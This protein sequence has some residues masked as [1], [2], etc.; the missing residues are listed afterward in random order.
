MQKP[1]KSE[2]R[3]LKCRDAW[4]WGQFHLGSRFERSVTKLPGSRRVW[5]DARYRCTVL[6]LSG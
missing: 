6:F 3:E 1:G 2:D 4:G 5:K